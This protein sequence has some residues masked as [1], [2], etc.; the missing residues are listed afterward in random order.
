MLARAGSMPTDQD[1]WSFEVKW[2]GV[3]A[4]VR[5][6]PERFELR[7]RADNVITAGYPEL[8]GLQ[9][10][11]GE[12]RAVLDGEI[13][14]FDQDGRPSFQALQERMHVRG[15]ELRGLVERRPVTLMLF[16]LPWLDGESL[17]DR[18]YDERRAALEALG[19]DGPHWQTPAAHPG[20]GDA[21]FAATAEQQLE[22]II[23]KRRDSHYV[24]GGRSDA[25]LKVKHQ[26]RQEFVVGGWWPGKGGRQGTLGSLQI[27]V[28][29]GD[30]RLRYAGGVG[31]GFDRD[32]L[33]RLNAQLTEIEQP[34]SPFEG[35]QPQ[36][37]TRFVDPTI[38]VEVRFTGWTDEGSVRQAAYLGVRDDKDPAD[39]VREDAPAV[40]VNEASVDEHRNAE[41]PD[42]HVAEGGTGPS[43]IDRTAPATD[44]LAS[45]IPA[46]GEVV[47]DVDDHPVKLTNLDKRYYPSGWT[48]AD[49]LRYYARIAP[50]ILPHLRDRP[51]TLMRYPDGAEGPSF[52]NKHAP[53]H[54]PEW[55]DTAR[56]RHGEDPDKDHVEFVLIQDRATLLWAAQLAAI[57]LHPSLSRVDA[58]RE[59]GAGGPAALV[60][61]LDP[62]PG[63][64]IVDCCWVATEVRALLAELGVEL[65]A[66][67]SG[68]KG[69]QLYAGL[70]ADVGYERS[71]PFAHAVAALLEERYPERV[72]SRMRKSLRDGKVLIDWS[73]NSAHKTTVC[74]YSLRA[75]DRPTV[76]TPVTWDEVERCR[77]SEDPD[78]LV[79]TAEAV[80]A[81]VDRDGDHFAPVLEDAQDLPALSV[82]D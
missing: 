64:T 49:V 25:W 32:T 2:D 38:V 68:S 50:A 78:Q 11:L 58:D 79:F 47:L 54:R 35:R 57:E 45:R 63:T 19:L 18:P 15:P 70:S 53:K 13:I 42:R 43:A 74:A 31:T 41:A 33:D 34:A 81:R 73:Q 5:S 55:V 28:H 10:A 75:R 62:G 6:S 60:F 16:D 4:S 80:L 52:F 9:D 24:P 48:K 46:R 26:R 61:D 72:V 3:R 39:V 40:T 22:G 14:A 12:H 36:R 59:S 21:L 82:D 65:L 7:S 56:V 27:G 8:A 23:A 51:V 29:D 69:L 67:T 30:G 71:K 76:S 1:D 44:G 66:K 20:R 17:V 37:G 77:A